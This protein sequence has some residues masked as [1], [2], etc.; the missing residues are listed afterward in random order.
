MPF[1]E[2]QLSA[3][4]VAQDGRIVMATAIADV[5]T[6]DHVLTISVGTSGGT[7]YAVGDTFSLDDAANVPL[8]VQGDSFRAVVRVTSVAAGVVDGVEL[9][10]A[11]A[12]TTLATNTNNATT[13]LTGAGTGCQIDIDTIQTALWTQDERTNLD[14]IDFQ[15]NG[16]FLATS[17]KAT[18]AP[19]MGIRSIISA[20]NDSIEL[21][22]G[23][24][25]DNGLP[26][27]AQAGSPV[28]SAF[29]VNCPNQDPKLYLSVSERRVNF[30]ITDSAGVNFQYGGIG[31]F[32]PFVDDAANYPFPGL[33][34]GQTTS[35]Q[36]FTTPYSSSNRGI[37]HPWGTTS[38]IC[39]QYRDNL[40]TEWLGITEDNSQSSNP[41]AVIWPHQGD[42]GAYSFSRAPVPTTPVGDTDAADM[43]PTDD[44]GSFRDIIWFQVSADAEAQGPAPLGLGSQLHF[45]SQVV[46]IQ[47]RPANCQL[48]GTV[49]GW[50][51][52]HGRGLNALDEIQTSSGRRYLVFPDTASSSAHLWVAMEIV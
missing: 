8:V 48:I 11:G 35:V 34:H 10:S 12:Y 31:L 44:G 7:G 23:S 24:S 19:L 13:T 40:S 1:I 15:T 51:A 6:N 45:T 21:T 41:R 43:V 47:N 46:I 5:I 49:D 39:Y 27:D 52:V 4:G 50:E 20:T 22:M 32:L 14:N 37:V 38:I 17:V 9:V 25:Y 26:W 30:L 28:S 16:D 29:F 3:D 36:A 18:N 2:Q 42:D 33:I